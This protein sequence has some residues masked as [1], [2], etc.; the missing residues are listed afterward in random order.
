M[1]ISEQLADIARSY[2][3]ECTSCKSCSTCKRSD[4]EVSPLIDSFL[5]FV[6]FFFLFFSDNT[7]HISTLFP[8]INCY[9]AMFVTGDIIL[10]VLDSSLFPWVIIL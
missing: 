7:L 4:N 9:Y 3:W 6:L 5:F 10:F 1:D 2:D 8:R